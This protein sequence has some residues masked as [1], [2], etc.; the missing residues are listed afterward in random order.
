MLIVRPPARP[1]ATGFG[2]KP[3]LATTRSTACFL[4]S[5]TLAVPFKMR[6]TVLGETPALRATTSSVVIGLFLDAEGPDFAIDPL[7][8][9]EVRFISGAEPTDPMAA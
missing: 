1:R 3:N 7:D 2:R 9:R 4:A 6:E 5:L 8:L